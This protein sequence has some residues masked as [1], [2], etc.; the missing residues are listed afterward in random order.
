MKLLVSRCLLGEPCRY[1]GRSV[2][3]EG[4][5]QLREEG[6]TLISVCPEVEG[7][8]ST[9]RPPAECRPD[10]RVVNR[11]GQDVTAQYRAGAEIALERASC[12]G[13]SAAIL[14][15]K[16][17]S[18][19]NERIYDGTFSRTLIPGQGIAARLLTEAGIPV[20]NEEQLDRLKELK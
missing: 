7:G 14:K 18:C 11:E 3:S 10:G 16:S 8:L 19:G 4:V 9:P 6:H 12:E 15:A 17:P 20:F 1:D 13:C 2:P 5:L